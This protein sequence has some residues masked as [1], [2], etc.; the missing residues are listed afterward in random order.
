MVGIAAGDLV[1]GLD[2]EDGK[3]THEGAADAQ[4]VDVHGPN[5]RHRADAIRR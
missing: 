4:D 1:P 5:S 3:A 2:G